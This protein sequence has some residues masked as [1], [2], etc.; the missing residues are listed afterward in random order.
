METIN[1]I[2]INLLGANF[3]CFILMLAFGGTID[4]V[5]SPVEGSDGDVLLR[6]IPDDDSQLYSCAQFFCTEKEANL[7]KDDP[8]HI[9][10]FRNAVPLES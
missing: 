3:N 4:Q 7:I 1:E 10:E 2:E 5:I 8:D 6:L 9:K